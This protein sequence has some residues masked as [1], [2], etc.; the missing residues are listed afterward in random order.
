MGGQHQGLPRNSCVVVLLIRTQTMWSACFMNFSSH[1]NLSPS[2]KGRRSIHVSSK[3]SGN[4]GVYAEVI[5]ISTHQWLLRVLLV[6]WFR[7]E[8]ISTLFIFQKSLYML[9]P[10]KTDQKNVKA[11]KKMHFIK[12]RQRCSGSRTLGGTTVA[13]PE[14]ASH[15]I[16][17]LQ[18][19][20]AAGFSLATSNVWN[21]L[22]APIRPA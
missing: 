21:T 8:Q 5:V 20:N 12:N 19:L 10:N 6:G 1:L 7:K 4:E 14:W 9:W 13:L 15:Q 22:P 17:W 11:L 3:R 16:Q 18:Q 2:S